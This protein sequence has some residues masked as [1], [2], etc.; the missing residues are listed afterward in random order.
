VHFTL[1]TPTNRD[2]YLWSVTLILKGYVAVKV[3]SFPLVSRGTQ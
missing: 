3:A 1:T 2:Q